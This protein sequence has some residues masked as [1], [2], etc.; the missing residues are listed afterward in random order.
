MKKR[1]AIA[2]ALITVPKVIIVDE[3]TAGL[4]PIERV[5]FRN[6]L[7]K[8]SRDRIIILSTHIVEDISVSCNDLAI[9]NKGELLF[10]GSPQ[11]LIAMASGNIYEFIG[12]EKD[13]HQLIEHHKVIYRKATLKGISLRFIKKDDY[14]LNSQQVTPTLEDAYLYLLH[15]ID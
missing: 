12:E 7:S 15:N 3:P 6:L 14:L 2:K 8:L 13:V 5:K 10:Q 1:I 4:D 11:E 9:I